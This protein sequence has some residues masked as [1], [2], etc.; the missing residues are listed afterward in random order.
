MAS[1]KY[2]LQ[3]FDC[4]T[5]FS[6]WQVEMRALLAQADYED[7]PDSFEN[8]CFAVWTYK[9]KRKDSHATYV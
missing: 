1:M 6:L 4:D 8:K 9:E 3:L 2:D 7:A 5:R